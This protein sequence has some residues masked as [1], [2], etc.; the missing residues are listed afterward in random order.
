M[1]G[2]RRKF[3]INMRI[4]VRT[5][6]RG[7]PRMWEVLRDESTRARHCTTRMTINEEGLEEAI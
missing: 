7:A 4:M 1:H 5:C 6:L 2:K 3:T